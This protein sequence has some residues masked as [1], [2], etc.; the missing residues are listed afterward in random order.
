MCQSILHLLSSALGRTFLVALLMT[1]GV[2]QAQDNR[3]QSG[4]DMN[5]GRRIFP[6]VELAS[7]GL[8]AAGGVV[9]GSDFGTSAEVLDTGTVAW[10]TVSPMPS[11]HRG[12]HHGVLLLSGEVLVAGEDPHSGGHPHPTSAYRYDEVSDTWEITA[13]DPTIDRFQA[14]LTLLPDG[15]VLFAGGYSGHGTGPTYNSAEVYDPS[16]DSWGATG[17]MAE[18]RTVHTATLLTTG[19]NA[20]KVLVVG[21]SDRASSNIATAGCE[22]YDPAAGTW[23]A[24]GSLSESRSQHTATLLP[25]GQVLVAGGQYTIGASTN[26]SSAELYDPDTG[27]WSPAAT[28]STPRALHTATP[29]PSG[30][31]L[32]AGGRIGP[33]GTAVLATA[34]IYHAPTDSWSP[35]A[36][37]VTPRA[38]HSAAS[39][40]DGRVIVVGGFNGG[41]SL[42]STE[43]FGPEDIFAAGFESGDF[44]AWIGLPSP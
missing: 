33:S 42:S 37:L 15:R 7:G 10:A 24:T 1:P 40:P 14:T 8:L 12:Q 18:V 36:S 27:T 11:P 5:T 19:P 13:N 44:S 30:K 25:S 28:M 3:W 21:G 38:L 16:T 6:L 20:G 41:T 32:V 9:T 35:V 23:S 22:L 39:L 26:R 34:E 31:I 43:I 4:T 29:L 17:T 2:G